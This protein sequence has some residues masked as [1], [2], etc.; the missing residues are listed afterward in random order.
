MIVMS[1]HAP[2]SLEALYDW[3]RDGG[4]FTQEEA[5]ER[6]GL[7]STRQVRRL[8]RQLREADVPMQERRRHRKKEY[9]M[10]EEDRRTLD[11]PIDLTDR[12]LL[13]LVV[14]AQV[15][16]AK[17]HPTPLASFLV[18]AM[19]VLQDT[20][21]DPAL[22]FEADTEP[23]HWHF[24]DA[25]SVP[26]DPD[27]FWTL[28]EAASA[29][30]SVYIDYRTA[31]SGRVS[32]DRKVD[33][34]LIAERRGSWLCVAYCHE[35]RAVRDF[36]IAGISAIRLCEDEYFTLPASFDRA[37]YFEG[38][39]GAVNGGVVHT[40]R[41][42]VDPDRAAYFRR[43]V[44]HPSQRIEAE[45]ENGYLIVAYRVRGLKEIAAW[46]RSWGAS[47]KVL[48]PSALAERVTAD[49]AAMLA[50]YAD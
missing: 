37:T 7:E 14:A 11:L 38:R 26:L 13:A 12:Q 45:R 1:I 24:G 32:T 19:G 17:L 4:A 22:S 27:V 30:Q 46:V 35:R 28:R 16:R 44:Y 31:S 3:L 29:Q 21:P 6:L 2:S 48:A 49:A 40:V 36:S 18:E 34:L 5:C 8:I 25:P 42:L 20:H 47:V 33:P 41:L 43:K 9:F 50:R 10:A 15:A 23:D 39:F